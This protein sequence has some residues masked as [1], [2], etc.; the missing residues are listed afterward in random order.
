SGGRKENRRTDATTRPPGGNRAKRGKRRR[1]RQPARENPRPVEGERLPPGRAAGQ[2][3]QA[4]PADGQGQAPRQHA[5]EL[6]QVNPRSRE[7]AGRQPDKR[8]PLALVSE[9]PAG[10][11]Q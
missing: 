11:A 2:T 8:P 5:E 7:R 9:S 4:E 10:E 1:E 6:G 3:Q